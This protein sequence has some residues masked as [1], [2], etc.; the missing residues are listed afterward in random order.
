[1]E[2]DFDMLGI[3]KKL[4]KYVVHLPKRK[5]CKKNLFLLIG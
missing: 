4:V 3:S 2:L 1:M 5:N